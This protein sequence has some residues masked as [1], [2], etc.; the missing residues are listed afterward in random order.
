MFASNSVYWWL[1]LKT[2]RG[3]A[4]TIAG[5]DEHQAA[6]GSENA[7]AIPYGLFLSLYFRAVNIS[8]AR[9]DGWTPWVLRTF[10]WP[11]CE[12][13]AVQQR[14]YVTAWISRVLSGGNQGEIGISNV[15][16][17]SLKEYEFL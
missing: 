5:P 3:T 9:W 4:Y 14:T 12:M 1:E 2:W 16:M 11:A 15:T 13:E 17:M 8:G 7:E 10:G 6:R